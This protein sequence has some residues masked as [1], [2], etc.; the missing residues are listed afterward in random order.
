IAAA[1]AGITTNSLRGTSYWSFA[2]KSGTVVM[3]VLDHELV[4][5]YAPTAQLQADLPL[6]LGLDLPAHSLA[7]T[8]TVPDTLKKY[9]FNRTVF[10]QV[11]VA[12]IGTGLAAVPDSPV[13]STD[14]K[15]DLARLATYTPRMV[16]GYRHLDSSGYAVG[17]VVETSPAI[18]EALGK[19]HA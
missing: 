9:G 19:L 7:E 18:A 17:F 16:G 6:I 11:D 13:G 12:R 4:V 8:M 5:G 2:G 15:G 3:A 14:C 1:G 10:M